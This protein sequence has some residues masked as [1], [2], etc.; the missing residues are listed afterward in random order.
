MVTGVAGHHGACVMLNVDLEHIT[1]RGHVTTLH[2]DM[3]ARIASGASTVHNPANSSPAESVSE[4]TF[5]VLHRL[6]SAI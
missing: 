3:A 5:F 4:D 6:P 2:R 1:G